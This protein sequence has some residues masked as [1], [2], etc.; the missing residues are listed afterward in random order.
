MKTIDSKP[1]NEN[2][3][4]TAEDVVTGFTGVITGYAQYLTGCDQYLLSAKCADSSKEACRV[5][6]DCNRL[7]IRDD[8]KIQLIPT[9]KTGA[10][11]Q[12]PIK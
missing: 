3:G 11:I 12:A 2:L 8:E 4:L 1:S 9:E 7:K 5:W 6:W 10:D